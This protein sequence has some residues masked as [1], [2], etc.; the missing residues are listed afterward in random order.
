[1]TVFAVVILGANGR[2]KKDPTNPVRVGFPS[3]TRPA[4]G[5]I[6]PCWIG[7]L[8]SIAVAN[9]VRT[10]VV[11]IAVD[12][13]LAAIARIANLV[14]ACDAVVAVVVPRAFRLSTNAVNTDTGNAIVF[15]ELTFVRRIGVAQTAA[16]A[17]IVR[18]FVAVVAVRV[19]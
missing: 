10:S 3:N 15:A 8:A 11:V 19:N 17:E 13:V 12:G 14:C 1:M 5:T 4:R 7:A 6:G 9:V 2:A 16:A 18:A